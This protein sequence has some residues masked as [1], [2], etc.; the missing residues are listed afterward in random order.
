MSWRRST[1]PFG[2]VFQ[3]LDVE[4]VEAARRANI[5]SIF[6]DLLDGRDAGEGQKETEMIGKARIGASDRFAR[7]QILGLER[8]AIHRQD[9]FCLGFARRRAGLELRERRRD[10]AGGYDRD[11]NVV[12][13][14]D[15]A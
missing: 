3:E 1:A 2:V 8:L 9:E 12:G 7:N 15:A 14:K 5:E 13:L 10:F 4:P 6:A 11:M